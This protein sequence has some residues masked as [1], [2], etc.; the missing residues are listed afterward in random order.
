MFLIDFVFDFVHGMYI[1][2]WEVV[3]LQID[4]NETRTFR[5]E[6]VLITVKYITSM[7]KS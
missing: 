7:N 4:Q 2:Q 1:E 3:I 6:S 5:E